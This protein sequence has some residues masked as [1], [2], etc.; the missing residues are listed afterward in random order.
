MTIWFEF[1]RFCLFPKVNTSR[2]WTA[3]VKLR[4]DMKPGHFDSSG[5]C[6][7]EN[8]SLCSAYGWLIY[9]SL[10]DGLGLLLFFKEPVSSRTELQERTFAVCISL[11]FPVQLLLNTLTSQNVYSKCLVDIQTS[12]KQQHSRL[13][14]GRIGFFKS[15]FLGAG[16]VTPWLRAL[17]ALAEGQGLVPLTHMAAHSYC[18]SRSRG[19]TLSSEQREHCM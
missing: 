2:Y 6:H 8:D 3:E 16:A 9:S 17:T 1:S 7:S 5:R 10:C 11:S 13:K 15:S 4:T 18:I 14:T 19:L 12:S